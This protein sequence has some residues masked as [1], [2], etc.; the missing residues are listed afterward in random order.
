MLR[1][2]E[3]RDIMNAADIAGYTLQADL[4]CPPC[5][6]VLIQKTWPE[7]F[8]AEQG[9]DV[10][11]R[12]IGINREDESSFDSGDFPKV[13]FV[14]Q[15]HDECTLENGYEPGQCGNQCGQCGNPLGF[16]CPNK[17]GA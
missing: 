12:F 9:L 16:E 1:Q 4:V 8:D 15:V 14:G 13:I 6:V 11:A 2:S 10:A 5:M 17:E 7:H 3:R